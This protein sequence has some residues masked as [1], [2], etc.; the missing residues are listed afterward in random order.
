MNA[1]EILQYLLVVSNVDM[2]V[3]GGHNRNGVAKTL[4]DKMDVVAK[5]IE[6]SKDQGSV[7]INFS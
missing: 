4:V 5:W 6:M 1:E 7:T 3:N 2:N